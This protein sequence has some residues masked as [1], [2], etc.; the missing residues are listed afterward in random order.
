MSVP[1]SHQSLAANLRGKPREEASEPRGPS[2][3][4]L[5]AAFF[6][7]REEKGGLGYHEQACLV[8][9]YCGIFQTNRLAFPATAVGS[10]HCL[11]CCRLS[12]VGAGWSQILKLDIGYQ[13]A[14]GVNVSSLQCTIV[15]EHYKFGSMC[16]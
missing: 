12:S 14:N 1:N 9:A 2:S 4:V 11:N 5:A 8:F 13:N 7:V 10:T 16:L 3:F 6:I 15:Q